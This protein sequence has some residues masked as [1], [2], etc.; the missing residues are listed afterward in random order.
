M[1]AGSS[2]GCA[3]E[4][5]S[6]SIVTED[7]TAVTAGQATLIGELTSLG[8]A[9]SVSVSFQ[10]GTASGSYP[11]E[12]EAQARTTA[13]VF[14]AD[15]SG[16]DSSTTYYYRVKAVGDST[17]YNSEKV[18]TTE[19]EPTPSGELVTY[20]VGDKWSFEASYEGSSYTYT[21]EVTG[22]GEA[23]GIDYWTFE[24]SYSE[25]PF[26]VTSGTMKGDKSSQFPLEVM[27]IGSTMGTPFSALV[28]Y[29]YQPSNASY[30]PLE[31]GK[32]VTVTETK[33]TTLTYD[34]QGLDLQVSTTTRTYNVQ[35]VE[36]V[37]V[38]AGTFKCFKVTDATSTVWLSDKAKTAVKTMT[39]EDGIT[40]EVELTSYSV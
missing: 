8:G 2:L 9:S 18:F 19:A 31:V 13:G 7:A 4:T 23:N 12:T 30:W 5:S 39:E 40:V 17:A 33:T 27:S 14:S 16:L 29:S 36:E 26:G 11:N 1:V 20:K 15:I 35:A 24:Q 6:P 28:T 25:S 34:G 10:W 3:T 21:V 32:E 22:E 38:Q 37:T